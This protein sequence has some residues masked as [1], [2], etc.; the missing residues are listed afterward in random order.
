MD[1]FKFKID[2]L[3]NKGLWVPKAVFLFLIFNFIFFISKS[4]DIHFTQ[5]N[6]SPLNLNPANAGVFFGDYR[7]NLTNRNQWRSVTAPYQTFSA[8]FDSKLL[9]R[10]YK[11]D[12]LSGG[13]IFYRD[14]AGDAGF[15][16]SQAN[17]ILSY[18]KGI[19]ELSK[20]FLTFGIEGGLAQRSVDY[21]KLTF[22]NQ[23]D[24]NMFNPN[25][26]PGSQIDMNNFIFSDI[27]A[28]LGYYYFINEGFNLNAGL[29]MFHINKPEQSF[30]KD[31]H[32]KLN[33]RYS[34]YFNLE[35]TVFDKIMLAPSV[36]YMQ[37][38]KYIELNFGT[39]VKF[40]KEKSIKN[41]TSFNIGVFTRRNDALNIIAGMDYRNYT[42]GL[43]YDINYSD[44]HKASYARGGY[45]ISILYRIFK[46]AKETK[47]KCRIM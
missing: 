21:S 37:Q 23:F 36:L 47:P 30:M 40:V 44:L 43:S 31:F 38:G 11:K 17:I 35:K 12:F 41:Y 4:Q 20:Q 14:K 13:I 24:G 27:S 1:N 34:A 7:I 10:K 29:A 22:D 2:R 9:L 42:V 26:V 32:A 28:G 18:T 25:I 46:S 6:N 3:N 45:E 33:P 39:F 5:F 15:G 8:S 19:D 16:T